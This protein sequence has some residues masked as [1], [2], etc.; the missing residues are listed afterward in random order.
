LKLF[1]G[2]GLFWGVEFV[3]DKASKRPFPA[4][5]PVADLITAEAIRRGVVV[6]P[7]M[8]GTAD[9]TLGDHVML[10]PPYIVTEEEVGIIVDTL[11]EAIKAVLG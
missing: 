7:G 2:K 3:S 9:G 8:K 6:Y 11:L 10:C 5:N 4:D 1:R